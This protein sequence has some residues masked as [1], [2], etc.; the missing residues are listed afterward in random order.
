MYQTKISNIIIK[1]KKAKN[2]NP[3]NTLQRISDET[4]VSMST[5]TRVFAD[6]SENHS[7]RYE[8]LKPIA[9]FL[10]GNDGLEDDVNSDELAMQVSQ[11][12]DKYEK[13]LEKEREQHR[14]NVSFLMQ[15]IDL[16]DAR[17]DQL[18]RALD[19]RNEQFKNL[20]ARF[21]ERE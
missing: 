13:K 8:S 14:K 9:L 16:K 20:M 2:E 4:G 12:K 21:L 18:M 3:E 15:Q 1:L 11:V 17:I 19:D 5:V 10:L 7:F 6:G